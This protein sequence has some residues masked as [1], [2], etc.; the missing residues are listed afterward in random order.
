MSTNANA[1][2]VIVT[3]TNGN[4]KEIGSA[5]EIGAGD[6]SVGFC[7]IKI[8]FTIL[9]LSEIYNYL[10]LLCVA[11]QKNTS[12]QSFISYSDNTL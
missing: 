11:S 1:Q 12:K 7:Q 9:R 3:D 8:T 10:I 2:A 6:N 4:I 5:I